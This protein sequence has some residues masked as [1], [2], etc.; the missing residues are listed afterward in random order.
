MRRIGLFV[1]FG[2]VLAG[3]SGG[4]DLAPEAGAAGEEIVLTDPEDGGYMGL[5]VGQE[6]TLV[7]DSNPTTGYFWRYDVSGETGAVV[8]AST[9]YVADPA[10]AGVVGSGGKQVFVFSG[11]AAGE[12]LLTFSYERSPEDVFETRQIKLIVLGTDE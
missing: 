12:A 3:C 7:F 11:V 1:V 4:T 9:D 10:P 2:L 8:E 5:V 6:V